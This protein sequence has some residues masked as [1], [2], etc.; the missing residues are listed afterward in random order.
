[1]AVEAREHRKVY[2]Y[3]VEREAFA[4]A[5]S[6]D[7]RLAHRHHVRREPGEGVDPA[8]R[9]DPAVRRRHALDQPR[10]RLR[11][12]VGADPGSP[13]PS[14][15]GAPLA[16]LRRPDARRPRPRRA[17]AVGGASRR[18]GPSR[19]RARRRSSSTR[20]SPATSWASAI[21]R[22]SKLLELLFDQIARPEFT[23]RFRWEP[24]SIAFWDNRATAHVGPIDETGAELRPRAS[25]A[26]PSSVTC[27]WDPTGSSRCRSTATCSARARRADP[28]S[29]DAGTEP[30][31]ASAPSRCEPR[32]RRQPPR[33]VARTSTRAR[34]TC[35]TGTYFVDLVQLA[36][37]GRLDF[38]TVDDSFAL[39]P[40]DG[41]GVRGRL[42]ALLTL[43]ARRAVDQLD[44]ARAHRDHHAHR[45]VPRLEERGHARLRQPRACRM[46]GRG[47][48]HGGR[49]RALRAQ[50]CGAARRALRGGGRRRR[51]RRAP[52]GQLGGRRRHPRPAD[53]SLHRPRQAPLRRLRGAVLRC[54][55]PVDHAAAAAGSA[56]RGRRRHVSDLALPIAG[57]FADLVFV[58]ALDPESAGRRRR[59]CP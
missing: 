10:R 51:R 3:E 28:R 45:A 23:V 57:S 35:S 55:R 31:A 43:A 49:S 38:V 37:R 22:A 29:S 32:R 27:P 50:G 24:D 18:A 21:A 48:D 11:G 42:D 5:A 25:S 14:P 54:A 40:A 17:A 7:D 20:S 15:G 2:R 47:V 39:Q 34:R 8:R 9:G 16:R 52:L 56:A 26:S 46:E 53:R 6:H 13:R 36:E 1:M 59:R 44:R 58:D 30:L 12:P 4:R 33:G 19:C 41:G